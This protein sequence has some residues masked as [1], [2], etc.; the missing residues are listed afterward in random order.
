M[1][2]LKHNWLKFCTSSNAPALGQIAA[3]KSLKSVL[4][5][6]EDT[7]GSIYRIKVELFFF[8]LFE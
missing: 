6:L 7:F 8:S 2:L 5:F 1:S 3:D 4:T